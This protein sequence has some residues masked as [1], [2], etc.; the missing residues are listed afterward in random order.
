MFFLP[1]TSAPLRSLI[2]KEFQ[3]CKGSSRSAPAH[4]PAGR[5][6]RNGAVAINKEAVVKKAFAA[7]MTVASMVVAQAAVA[8]V[9]GESEGAAAGRGKAEILDRL[10]YGFQSFLCLFSNSP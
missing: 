10:A 9:V 2:A 8:D 7:V 1:A 5:Q 3:D 4:S 6:A